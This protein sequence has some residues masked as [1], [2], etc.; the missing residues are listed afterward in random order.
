MRDD[1][2]I[3]VGVVDTQISSYPPAPFHPDK[4]YPE[5]ARAPFF[6]FSESERNNVYES[7]RTLFLDL[8]LDAL[9]A[10]T[11][12]WNPLKGFV[13]PGNR[14][15]IKP[16]LVID[17][18]PLGDPGVAAMITHASIIRP[19]IDY[20]LLATAGK[21]AITICDVPLQSANWERMVS[22]NGLRALV[23]DYAARGIHIDLLDLRYEVSIPNSE[24]VY[25][26]RIKAERDPQGYTIVSFGEKSYIQDIMHDYKKL[27][28]TDYGSGTV[29]K[30]HNPRANEYFVPKTILEADVFINVPKLKS[31]RKAGVTLSMKN[32]IGI[33]GDKSWIAHHRK[34]VD[35]FPEFHLIPYLKW[36]VSYYLKL[37]APKW[38]VTF[39]YMLHRL[40]CLK[41]E[42]LKKHGMQHGGILMEGNW[43]GN[44]TVWR[45]ILDLNNIIFFADKNGVL[46]ETQQRKYFTLIDGVIGMDKEGPMEGLP[47]ASQVI[48][49]GFHPVAVDA[50]AAYLM[51]FDWQK[52]PV[53]REGFC[54]KHFG[55][56]PFRYEDIKVF[57][58][59]DWQNVNYSFEATRGWKGHIER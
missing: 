51:G 38:F 11:E 7:V 50:V 36:Y 10:Q 9:H 45:T 18:H 31:H 26:K 28:I 35:E 52:I 19:L 14:V 34:G 22:F 1:Q 30:H 42:S 48:I 43:H 17:T 41:G 20:V 32:L 12:E 4:A 29:S 56:T 53:I 8:G 44:D 37:Y 46:K 15:V 39:M 23:D 25:F 49:G 27:E 5:F 6:V 57:S 24:G 59:F 21:C 40:F 16:N 47:K 13:L 58:S 55:L 33:N 54:E 3:K 2:A